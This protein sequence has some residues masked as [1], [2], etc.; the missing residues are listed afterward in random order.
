M[1][2]VAPAVSSCFFRRYASKRRTIT[3][4]MTAPIVTPVTRLTDEPDALASRPRFQPG[5]AVVGGS[6]AGRRLRAVVK[7]NYKASLYLI[8]ML[9]H[10]PN[11]SSQGRL[12]A[13]DH[14]LAP[15]C[16]RAKFVDRDSVSSCVLTYTANNLAVPQLQPPTNYLKN[17]L[18]SCG[19]TYPNNFN[20]LSR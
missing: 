2:F 14:N 13:L 5:A 20:K 16:L 18:Q 19:T 17:S 3:T 11:N 7:A 15:D 8:L 9:Y 6:I 12:V 10:K 1:L 4:N